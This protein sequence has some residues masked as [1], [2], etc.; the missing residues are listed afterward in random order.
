MS[1]LLRALLLRPQTCAFVREQIIQALSACENEG[2][3]SDAVVK[4]LGALTVLGSKPLT[5]TLT[6][7]LTL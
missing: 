5:L 2:I 1:A 6:L 7:T 4:A 3:E